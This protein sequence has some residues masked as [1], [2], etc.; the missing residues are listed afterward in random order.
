[1]AALVESPTVLQVLPALISGGVERGTLE[2]AAAL[3]AVGWR[4]LVA[5]AGGPLVKPLQAL[6]ATHITLP[7]DRKRP[8]TMW[9]NAGTLE[10]IIRREKVAIVHARSR[11]PAWS[12]WLAAQRTGSHFL[13]TYHGTYNNDLPFKRRWNS[14]M[15]RGERVIAISDFIARHV[16]EQHGTPLE[17]IRVIPRGVDPG[18]FDPTAVMPQRVDALRR[19]WKLPEAARVLLLPARLTRWKGQATLIQ[20][21]PHL[22]ENAVAV[23]LGH[24]KPAYREELLKLASS[25]G[26]SGRV[27]LV[28]HV[29]DMPA[30]LLA[31]DVVVHA[32]TDPEAFGRT[33]VEG[34]A[35][36]R[37]VIAADLGAPREVIRHGQDGWL[38]APGFP[39]VLADAIRV[40]LVLPPAELKLLGQ[41]ARA[42]VMQHFT[43]H[44][45]QQAT[46][47]VYWELL[48]P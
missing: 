43:T 47:D 22:P 9:W 1:M 23:L 31:A 4:A 11:A 42:R 20:A 46:L 36:A 7:L 35:M 24:G 33:V 10:E 13:T 8:L 39:E 2:M 30:A 21:L 15:A 6:G 28:G 26:V 44:Q 45:M 40:A 5:S 19:D 27:R 16:Q 3:R 32:S 38:V 48:N 12:A 18:V 29:E 41:Q 14:I 25:L 37:P 34:M 17:R